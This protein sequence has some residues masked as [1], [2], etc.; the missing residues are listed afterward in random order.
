MKNKYKWVFWGFF[1]LDYQAMKTYL[2]E[3]AE[4][5]WMLEKIGLQQHLAKFR[6]IEPQKLRFYVDVFKEGGP[7]TPEKTEESET[8]RKLCEESGWKFITSQD[9]LQFFY[10]EADSDP[11][12]I[13]TDEVIEQEIVEHTLLRK[14]LRGFLILS[15]IVAY[16][17]ISNIPVKYNI[18]L[19]FTGVSGIF[20]LPLIF[21]FAAIPAVYSIIR[22]LRAR[23]NIKKGYPIEK[24][25]MKNA[26]R[27]IILFYGSTG[28]ILL[29]FMLFIIVDAFYMPQIVI[30]AMIGPVIGIIVGLG[31]RYYT[32]KKAAKREDSIPVII[33]AVFMV[34]IFIYTVGPFI[35]RGLEDSYKVTSVPEGY[36]IITLEE[37]S[38]EPNKISTSTREFKRGSS[39]VTPKHYSYGEYFNG[40]GYAERLNVEYYK[41]IDPYYAEIIFNGIKHELEKGFEWKGMTIFDRTIISDDEMKSLWD[42]DNLVLTQERDVLIMQKGNIVLNF[43]G[44]IDFSDKQTRELIIRRFFSDLSVVN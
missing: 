26:R 43:S 4:K 40:N 3:M 18:L 23:N 27:R 19:S 29:L 2:E 28:I 37:I 38:K 24:P 1:S 35:F 13:Q 22:I 25:T 34:F 44:D 11:V 7:L 15:L 12:P 17:L 6:A 14:E 21:I 33:F 39:P 36:P 42:A 31:L 5:G 32:K 41:T 8:Y 16:L 20:L 30:Q 10:A 9:Y